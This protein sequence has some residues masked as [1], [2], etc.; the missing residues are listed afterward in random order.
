M[1]RHQ[2]T[3]LH[4]ISKHAVSVIILFIGSILGYEV[5]HFYTMLYGLHPWLGYLFGVIVLWV[6]GVAVFKIIRIWRAF[7]RYPE[8]PRPT[9]FRPQ[10]SPA[11]L[12]AYGVYLRKYSMLLAENRHLSPERREA[13][14]ADWEGKGRRVTWEL[15]H[16]RE[17]EKIQ[18]A[19]EELDRQAEVLIRNTV[20]DTMAA[21]I[22][23]PFR[24]VDSFFIM[25]RNSVLFGQ[26][27]QL[28][29]HRPTFKQTGR[30]LLDVLKVVAAVNVLSFTERFTERLMSQMP[31]LDRTTDDLLQ[32]LGAGLLTTAIGRATQQRCHT[33]GPW[34]AQEEVQRYRTVTKT[35]VKYVRGIFHE[36]VIPG[37]SRTWLKSW[38][39]MKDLFT[40]K[41]TVS[42]TLWE[43]PKSD[44]YPL[45]LK[46]AWFRNLRMGKWS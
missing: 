7:P 42:P 31:I 45:P 37:L 21:V 34:E 28:Y 33:I 15:I 44:K 10:A 14:K 17:R 30:V 32:G 40:R 12:R 19:I 35:F 43:P 13:L 6:I 9:R 38:H 41:E 3:L 1:F 23:S 24:A 11:Y 4:L 46:R 16:T 18:P 39:R 22:L 27:V 36:D 25:Y 2:Y 20:R 8:P 26:L 29:Y 5:V